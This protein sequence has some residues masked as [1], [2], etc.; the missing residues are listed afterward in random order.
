MI[1]NILTTVRLFLVPVFAYLLLKVQNLPAA[2]VVL[3][4]SGATDVVDGYIARRFHMVSDF[5]KVYDPFVDKLMQITSV[6]CLALAGIIP[7]G[8]ILIVILKELTMI[9]IGG[10]LYLKKIVVHSHWY[11][12]ATTVIFYTI[13][14]ILIICQNI[15]HAWVV[16][17]LVVLVGTML[18][19]AVA[20]LVDIIKN[21]EEKRVQ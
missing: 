2:A 6:I 3:I 7:F 8:V 20:Y 1:P 21:F 9:V 4:L 13:I 16:G 14:F 10:I 11:G 18:A 15:S 19:S 12:K 5:G 17:L